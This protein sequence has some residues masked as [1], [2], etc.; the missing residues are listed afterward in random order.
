MYNYDGSKVA[1]SVVGT[2]VTNDA[3]NDAALQ[4][5]LYCNVQVNE[6][7]QLS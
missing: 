7:K 4:G 1:G 2:V 6:T 3:N 5:K